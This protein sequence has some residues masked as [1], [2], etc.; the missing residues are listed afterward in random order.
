MNEFSK[1]LTIS[2]ANTAFSATVL[3][4]VTN[5]DDFDKEIV[6]ASCRKLR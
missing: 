2:S 3:E 4:R 5:V 6:P 1:D